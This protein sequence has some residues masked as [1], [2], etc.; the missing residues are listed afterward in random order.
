MVAGAGGA[1][2]VVEVDEQA[3][4][5]VTWQDEDGDVDGDGHEMSTPP[6]LPQQQRITSSVTRTA[7]TTTTSSNSTLPVANTGAV[8]GISQIDTDID[9]PPNNDRTTTTAAA[10][11]KTTL[12]LRR[13]R[14]FLLDVTD[15]KLCQIMGLVVMALVVIDGAFFFFLLVG[16]HD[17]CDTPS[18]TNCDPRNWWYNFSIQMLVVLFTYMNMVSLPWRLSQLLHTYHHNNNNNRNN[19]GGRGGRGRGRKRRRLKQA[20]NNGSTNTTTNDDND[21]D[22]IGLDLNF[23]KSPDLWYHI[24]LKPHRRGIL[25]LLLC[26]SFTQFI[27]Q[28][29]RIKFYSYELQNSFPATIWVNLFFVASFVSAGAGGVWLL[30]VEKQIRSQHPPNT[31]PPGLLEVIQEQYTQLHIRSRRL[32]RNCCCCI[33]DQEA[34]STT[35]GPGAASTSGDTELPTTPIHAVEDQFQ[36]D[37]VDDSIVFS[38]ML[39]RDQHG[40]EE[41]DPS[42]LIMN[43][44]NNN[45][46]IAHCSRE[47]MRLFAM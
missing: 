3:G 4:V 30:V 42:S 25:W 47:E 8:G 38:R 16:W 21:E 2:V 15:S 35:A 31:F 34:S 41:H 22:T 29:T 18:K 19:T 7:T 14:D 27:N 40:D 6:P 24:P 32:F 5:P 43:N 9:D 33:D 10:K 17:M 13:F 20:Q 45:N 46:N 44:I 23:E 12:L 26:S 28:A 11:P 37:Q 39:E 36:E 1:A